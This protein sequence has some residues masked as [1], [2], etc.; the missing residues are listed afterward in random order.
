[1]TITICGDGS[2]QDDEGMDLPGEQ[3]DPGQQ[4]APT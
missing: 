2:R 4:A 3:I 1:L